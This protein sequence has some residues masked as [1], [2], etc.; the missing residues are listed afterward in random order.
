MGWSHCCPT[1]LLETRY[2]T[3]L[4]VYIKSR[5]RGHPSIYKLQDVYMVL[6]EWAPNFR[7]LDF[8]QWGYGDDGTDRVLNRRFN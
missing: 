5:A 3:P 7:S 1:A 4:L 6:N 8:K 2:A